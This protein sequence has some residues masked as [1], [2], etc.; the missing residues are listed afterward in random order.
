M[1][2]GN[3]IDKTFKAGEMLAQA[4]LEKIEMQHTYV[5]GDNY[6]FMNMETFEEEAMSKEKF[7]ANMEQFLKE[8]QTVT[9]LKYDQEV[10]DV[11]LPKTLSFVVSETDPGVK[12]NTA[13]GGGSKPAIIE[14]GARIMVPLF[15][16][17]GDK[18]NVNTEEGKYL[19]RDNS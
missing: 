13:Q 10:L 2:T 15:I 8:G 6:M 5:D 1:R 14:T 16:N 17:P 12:G 4:T 11:D 18:I 3:T 7:R 19:S 9:V